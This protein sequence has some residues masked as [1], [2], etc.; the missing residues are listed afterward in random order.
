[1]GDEEQNTAWDL[2]SILVFVHLLPSGLLQVG[3]ESRRGLV[4][5]RDRSTG[6]S[7]IHLVSGGWDNGLLP[8]ENCVPSSL[9]E[10]HR[11]ARRELL[12]RRHCEVPREY[13]RLPLSRFRTIVL[14][15]SSIVSTSELDSRPELRGF[16][17]VSSHISSLHRVFGFARPPLSKF[18]LRATDERFSG[19][20]PPNL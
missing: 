2:G 20:I 6:S 12:L 5:T 15:K 7:M 10:N 16:P 13:T 8:R 17:P 11:I 19:A 1:M 3:P 18:H 14:H 9:E 4:Q